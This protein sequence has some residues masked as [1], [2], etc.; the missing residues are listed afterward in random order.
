[1]AL[2]IATAAIGFL[3]AASAVSM[4]T[5]GTIS[6]VKTIKAEQEWKDINTR[7]TAV[8][9]STGM[10]SLADKL[11]KNNEKNKKDQKD[12][13]EKIEL[14]NTEA[15]LKKDIETLQ[16]QIE[17]AQKD[18]GTANTQKTK[19]EKAIHTLTEM[20]RDLQNAMAALNTNVNANAHLDKNLWSPFLTIGAGAPRYNAGGPNG[21]AGDKGRV[22]DECAAIDGARDYQDL[23][24][25]GTHLMT[26]LNLLHDLQADNTNEAANHATNAQAGPALNFLDTT[27]RPELQEQVDNIKKFKKAIAKNTADLKAKKD[28]LAALQKKNK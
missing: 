25:A 4:V 12:Q 19:L 13:K 7:V 22:L 20:R 15:Q 24:G 9:N 2:N 17:Q 1:M 27:F 11:D 28:E 8:K 5:V 23:A 6:L 16:A 14:I 18:L 3:L 26:V 21:W 10:S